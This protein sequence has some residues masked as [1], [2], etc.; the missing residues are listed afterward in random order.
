MRFSRGHGSALLAAEY[1]AARPA[2]DFMPESL[3]YNQEFHISLLKAK[4]LC[5]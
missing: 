2:I 3:R 4:K 5:I 1:A